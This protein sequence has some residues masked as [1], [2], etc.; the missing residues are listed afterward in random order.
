[1]PHVTTDDG[2]NLY[3]EEAGSGTPI[4]FVHEFAG[5]WRSWEPQLRHFARFYR[6]ITY[7]AR[8]FLPS[9]VPPDPSSYSQDRARDD[10]KA[11]LDGLGIEKAHIVGLSMG[12]F[13][14]LHF[15]FTYPER[16]LSLVIGGCGYGAEPGKRDQFS[17]EAN[18]A[19]DGFENDGM[20]K[21]GG[22]YALGPT[23]VQFQNNDPR[24][25]AEFRDQL[26]EHSAKG[27]ANTMR[28]VQSKRPSLY[29]LIDKMRTITA[30]TLVITGDEDWPCLEPSLL[31]KR[32]IQ[33]AALVVI[34]NAG[35]TI[36]IETPA[37]FN[38]QIEAFLHLVDVGR[39]PARDPRS[40][41]GK[42]ISDK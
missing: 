36:N 2:V 24:G 31:M 40:V 17:N 41:S 42:I 34:P 25:W 3:Y 4:V 14:T 39:W 19:A 6:C 8:G 21:A 27:S 29:E 13:A 16:C 30:P 22:A 7:S 26:I 1:M 12:G 9:D 18:A 11:V 20:E 32:E 33:T 10:I 23:R 38:R 15:G 35:H 5:D 37:E 28:G